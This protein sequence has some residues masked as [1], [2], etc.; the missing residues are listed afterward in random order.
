MADRPD[1]RATLLRLITGH[2]RTHCLYVVAKLGVV[3][4]VPQ[5]ETANVDE[6]AQAVGA[7]AD[8]LYRVLR[9]LAGEGL[10]SE[11]APR[12]F[13]VTDLGELMRDGDTS[14]RYLALMHGGQTMELFRDMLD[15]VQ[16]GTP[17]PMLRYGKTR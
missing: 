6:I 17:V 4:R 5:G 15:S 16:T 11:V 2:I 9:L 1:E 12:V 14:A 3:D 7:N 13:A 10:F 8:A